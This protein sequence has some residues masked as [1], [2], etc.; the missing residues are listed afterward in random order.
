M[1][2]EELRDFEL[3]ESQKMVRVMARDFARKEIAP[4]VQQWEKDGQYPQ[5]IVG[6]MGKPQGLTGLKAKIKKRN[7]PRWSK[8]A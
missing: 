2:L 6:K 4:D 8:A 5:D 7:Q 1:R 3:T